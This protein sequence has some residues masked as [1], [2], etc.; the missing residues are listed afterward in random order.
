MVR[1]LTSATV[2]CAVASVADC[3][4]S[5]L[6]Y[7]SM[8]WLRTRDSSD[9]VVEVDTL[10]SH[11]LSCIESTVWLQESSGGAA[12]LDASASDSPGHTLGRGTF[13][14][15]AEKRPELR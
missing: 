1:T 14:R 7:L 15:S 3:L 5:L 6:L 2:V 11:D 9:L 8:V 4:Q 13:Q 10:L 12:W